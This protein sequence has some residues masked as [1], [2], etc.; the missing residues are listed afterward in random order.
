MRKEDGFAGAR[1]ADKAE[2]FAALDVEVDALENFL[3]TEIDL[4]V[5]HPQGNVL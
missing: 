3:A 1:R 5:A 2:H 4:Q